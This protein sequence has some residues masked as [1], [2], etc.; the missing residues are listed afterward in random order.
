MDAHT[1]LD[2]RQSRLVSIV[3][4]VSLTG[5][6]LAAHLNPAT[7]YEL[8]IY[9]ATPLAFW[10]G[11]AIAF[12]A[13]LVLAFRPGE[14]WYQAAGHVLGGTASTA[15]VA[16][17]LI[18]GYYF[19]GIHDSMT[20]VGWTREL[21]R[22]SMLPLDLL[23][24]GIHSVAAFVGTLTGFS[25][26]QS[27]LYVPILLVVV[28]FLFV[29]LIVRELLDSE[30]ATAT[31]SFSAFLLVP[32]HLI[33][34]T[35]HAHPSSQTIL[36]A[37]LV[38][39]LLVRFV[40]SAR[41]SQFLGAISPVG[42]A[43]LVAVFASILYHPQQALNIIVLL[44]G[45]T[46]VQYVRTNRK[47]MPSNH[48]RT[49]AISGIALVAYVA[50]VV[51]SPT[52]FAVAQ[53]GIE[54]VG[55]YLAGSSSQAGSAVTAQTSS[56]QAIGASLP[57]VFLKLFFVSA[58]FVILTAAVLGATVLGRLRQR[59]ARV[60]T[61]TV[62]GYLGF[63]L[64][65]MTAVFAFYLVGDIATHY[66]RQAGFMLML[67][68]ILGAVGIA[69]ATEQVSSARLRQVIRTATVCMFVV[70]ASLSVLVIYDS[71]YMNKANQQ[72]TEARADGYETTFE[73][74]GESAV[75]AG[76]GQEPQRYYDAL[77]A[78]RD[79]NRR[80][81]NVNS[82]EIRQLRDYRDRNWYLT[83][84]NNTYAREVEAYEEYRFTRTDLTGTSRQVGV[85]RV[86]ANGDMEL[87]Y[88]VTESEA[89]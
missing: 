2:N 38:V 29:P 36:F 27:M 23:Y 72:V 60:D 86:H 80:D 37:P 21:I 5:A 22:G 78:T 8:S 35:L 12:I 9:E 48:Q 3:G 87:Y 4:F 69:Y 71:P 79:N 83:I 7:G 59:P 62:V 85:N 77:V 30:L 51:Q 89:E 82:S 24:P 16:L 68:T 67:G 70:M 65:V 58:V 26:W 57:V 49:Y 32:L 56:L 15:V 33:A 25:V 34:N 41:A 28:F 52:V 17:P 75:M 64:V 19:M 66:F 31:G 45:V 50:W 44:A 63:G 53:G 43:L 88:V 40:R 47:E 61:A 20:H 84:H 13:G 54:S 46:L 10:I 73:V 6:V 81:R 74:T 55:E 14:G 1:P 76:I 18:R 39:F 42:I 11:I